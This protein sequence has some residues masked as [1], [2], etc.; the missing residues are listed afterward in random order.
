MANSGMD[1]RQNQETWHGF[2]KFTQ[3]ATAFLV[4]LLI[5][6]AYFLVH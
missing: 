1:I 6:M 4:I 3:Y 5:L 2:V